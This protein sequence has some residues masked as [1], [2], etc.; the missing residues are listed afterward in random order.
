MSKLNIDTMNDFKY[1]WNLKSNK[2]KSI[3]TY[4]LTKPNLA[5]NR[6]DSCIYMFDGKEHRKLTNEGNY[7]FLDN[8]NIYFFSKRTDEDKENENGS[9][10]YKLNIEK[11]GE[12]EKFLEFDFSVNKIYKIHDDLYILSSEYSLDNP[13]FHSLSKEEKSKYIKETKDK[14]FRRI[15]DEIPFWND[16][17]TYIS[18]S[19]N[20]IFKYIPS[21]NK[22][23]NIT[24]LDGTSTNILD[25]DNNKILLI[26]EYFDKK[27]EKYNSLVEYDVKTSEIKTIVNDGKYS[28]SNA[29]YSKNN[30]YAIASL[31]EFYGIN[32]NSKIFKINRDNSEIELYLDE[33]VSYGN[34]TG[35]D[36][37]F[38]YNE[39]FKVDYDTE[40]ITYICTTEYK[41]ELHGVK[42]GKSYVISDSLG[43][44][45]GY[46]ILKNELYLLGFK[47][48]KLLEIYKSNG[49]EQVTS[50]N[51]DIM[52]DK[53]IAEPNMFE[54][55][56]NGDIIKGFVLLPENFDKNKSYPAI[57]DIHGGP[58]TVYSTI[59]YHE[60]QVWVNKGYVVMFTNPHGSSGR[61]DKFSDIRGKYGTIDYE[62]L[63]KFVDE[64]LIKYPN[65]DKEKLAVTGGSYGGFM[66]NWII[67]HTDRFKV[68]A[69]QRSISNWISMY[70]ISDIGYYFSDDQNYT[71][72]PNEKGFE[73]IWNHSPLK[74]IENAKTP[75]LIIHSNE[76]Y[77]C[78]VDQGYQLFTAL[79]DRNVDTKMVLFYGE[80]HGLSRGGKPKARIERLEEITN[81]INKYTK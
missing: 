69:T 46:A 73:K 47:D 77:R 10:I 39:S 55:E 40:E 26:S 74:Y 79:R 53:Y 59:Y 78:P 51:D 50:Y 17:S 68:A 67:T 21:E 16:G 32:E 56:S 4:I 48:F 49:L 71:T 42:D 22:V 34:A 58:K 1:I 15:I 65:I 38:G 64:T 80:S 13:E 24:L 63:M 61:G 18:K 7:E 36:A 45:D 44:V 12:A 41:A 14:S 23:E 31:M 35:T 52:K 72:L 20:A 3:L 9:V 30:I 76:D 60:M 75:T 11:S 2:D 37:R 27:M 5:K 43:S 25:I 8:S 70:G 62:D 81:W 66:T 19:R 33:D 57:L 29:K 6:Y 28:F 54:F